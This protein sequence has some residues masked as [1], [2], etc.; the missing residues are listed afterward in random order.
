MLRLGWRGW[1]G[2]ETFCLGY[3]DFP[4]AGY[5]VTV[6]LAASTPRPTYPPTDLPLPLAGIR[7]TPIPSVDR[8][9]RGADHP[10]VLVALGTVPPMVFSEALRDIL[11]LVRDAG[12][13]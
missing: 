3:R 10:P 11:R 9:G 12:G 1:A 8:K 4:G 2:S 5:R 7:F 6:D 13:S